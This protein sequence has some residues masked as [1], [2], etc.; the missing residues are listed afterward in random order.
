MA[1]T[2]LSFVFNTRTQTSQSTRTQNQEGVVQWTHSRKCK[3]GSEHQIKLCRRT[4]CLQ[5]SLDT[6]RLCWKLMTEEWEE[7]F[8]HYC[9]RRN[10]PYQWAPDSKTC[11]S[12]Q[13]GCHHG[14]LSA[15]V[16]GKSLLYQP[17]FPSPPP[18]NSAPSGQLYTVAGSTS[19][20]CLG[21]QDTAASPS[22]ASLCTCSQTGGHFCVLCLDPTWVHRYLT[23]R[24]TKHISWMSLNCHTNGL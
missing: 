4:E 2:N 15:W 6:P 19:R 13:A 22:T 5:A 8:L 12:S 18:S 23:E 3:G 11:H 14:L 24:K 9:A 21:D 17:L 16:H 10:N 1:K 7:P 20:I